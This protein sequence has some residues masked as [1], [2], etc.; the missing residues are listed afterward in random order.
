MAGCLK[1]FK[2]FS[3]VREMS[4]ILDLPVILQLASHVPLA[5]LIHSQSW[6]YRNVSDSSRPV[7]SELV[8]LGEGGCTVSS[9]RCLKNPSWEF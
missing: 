4:L 7:G 6:D 1:D 5:H 9:P 2:V 3:V 8:E